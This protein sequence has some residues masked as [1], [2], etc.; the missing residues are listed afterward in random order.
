MLFL[1][2]MP[3]LG[4]RSIASLKTTRIIDET[5]FFD[6]DKDTPPVDTRRQ[7]QELTERKRNAG[8][9]SEAGCPGVADP[10]RYLWVWPRA[11]LAG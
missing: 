9:L 10:A 5:T 2:K 6:L 1:S 8:V 7:I 11:R 4:R 3:A